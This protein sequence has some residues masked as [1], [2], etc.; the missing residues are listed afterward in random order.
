MNPSFSGTTARL[1]AALGHDTEQELAAA[2]GLS[3]TAWAKRKMRDSFPTAAA[4]EVIQ[5][6]NLN[7]EYIYEGTGRVYVE[8]EGHT[9]A[10]GLAARLKLLSLGTYQALLEQAGHKGEDV[11]AVVAGKKEPGMSLLRDI[12]RL[13][14]ADLNWLISGEQPDTPNAE[15]QAVLALYRKASAAQQKAVLASL[16]MGDAQEA[17]KG[18][19]APVFANTFSGPV[20]QIN[21][22]NKG[23]A[24]PTV[25]MSSPIKEVQRAK[26]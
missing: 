18:R 7:P 22:V 14:R 4:D 20:G 9:W 19:S 11:R 17:P 2:L 15:E 3:Q 24:S 23:N 21:K 10:D 1:M 16:V 8:D 26:K 12:R 13:S 25:N 6:E 5:R